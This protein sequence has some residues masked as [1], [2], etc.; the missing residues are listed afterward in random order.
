MAKIVGAVLSAMLVSGCSGKPPNVGVDEPW[1]G[2]RPGKLV[3]VFE[4][5][6]I[7]AAPIQYL[8][9]RTARRLMA[10]DDSGMYKGCRY[11]YVEDFFRFKHPS[12]DDDGIEFKPTLQETYGYDEKSLDTVVAANYGSNYLTGRFDGAAIRASGSHG[13]GLDL[14]GDDELYFGLR[15]PS[16]GKTLADDPEYVTV[17]DCLGDVYQAAF[18]LPRKGNIV[19]SLTA[20]GGRVGSDGKPES[21]LCSLTRSHKDADKLVKVLS[22]LTGDGGPY[23]GA[24]ISVGEGDTPMVTMTWKNTGDAGLRPGYLPVVSDGSLGRPAAALHP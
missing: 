9:V 7:N 14:I 5:I 20:V 19:Y 16:K 24:R 13:L 12:S 1:P 4:K 8:D 15:P 3:G 10:E 22:A 23:R 11:Y 21:K 6:P 17:A 18:D 2:E